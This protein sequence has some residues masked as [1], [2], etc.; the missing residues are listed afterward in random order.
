MLNVELDL[1]DH[2]HVPE[3]LV[4]G[5]RSRISTATRE[6]GRVI[7]T[8]TQQKWGPAKAVAQHL[9]QLEL[10]LQGLHSLHLLLLML[11]HLDLLHGLQV[12]LGLGR[13]GMPVLLL[14]LLVGL[15]C[16][17]ASRRLAP[18]IGDG[19]QV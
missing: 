17:L 6:Q 8:G 1:P 11:L 4:Q 7:H 5:S 19:W 13:L 14:L 12:C 9:L 10:G 3:W 18:K 16:R 2:A 15:G